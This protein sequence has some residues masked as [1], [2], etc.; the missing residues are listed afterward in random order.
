MTKTIHTAKT[1]EIA[2]ARYFDHR[3]NIIIPNISTGMHLNHEAD[4]LILNPNGYAT[5]I[6]IK[7][8]S[9][10]IKADAMK[11]HHHRS[12]KIKK[13]YYAVPKN[14]KDCQDLPK[15][16]GLICV[17]DNLNC[18]TIRAPRLN[19]KAVKFTDKE[20]MHL[21]HLGCMRIWNLKEKIL[22]LQTYCKT[23]GKEAR[24]SPAR[25]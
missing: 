16:C 1:M 2:L 18:T 22:N 21:L 6:E 23:S 3:I 20:I 25:H 12:R 24:R 14:L 9:S 8:S 4:L 19:T 15:D 7:V 13:F 5:E 10:D 11:N 17:D